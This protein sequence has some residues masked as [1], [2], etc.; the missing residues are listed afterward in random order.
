MVVRYKEDE[1]DLPAKTEQTLYVDLSAEAAQART[2]S[3]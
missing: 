1:L 2:T 3:S